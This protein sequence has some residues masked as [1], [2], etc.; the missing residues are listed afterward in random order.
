MEKIIVDLKDRSYPIYIGENIISGLAEK[1]SEKYSGR[2]V[3]VVS[4]PLIF[5]YYG[6]ELVKILKTKLD[7]ITEII[8]AG[9]EYKTFEM[10][11]KIITSMIE[12][13]FNRDALLIALGGGVVGDLAGFAASIYQRGI[14][15]IQVPT[16]LLAQVDSSVGGKVAVNHPLGKNLIGSFYQPKEVWIDLNTL[17]TLPERE[18]K[19]G[20][21]EVI[22]YG[23]LG[24]GS[25][26]FKLEENKGKL[27]KDNL[28]LAKEIIR[29]SCEIKALVVSKDEK[30]ENLRA[31]LNLGHTLGHA[32]ESATNY[33]RYRHGEAIA[34][35]MVLAAKLAVKLKMLDEDAKI[36]IEN[37][38][39][40][41]GLEINLPADVDMDLI[42]NN[43]YLDKKIKNKE[44]VFVLPRKIG[45]VEVVTGLDIKDVTEVCKE[46]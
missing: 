38:I 2:Q 28:T 42:I 25:F 35:G 10:A 40:G 7:C 6:E 3:I 5:S 44:L 21:A 20:L 31:I 36:R 11:E 13:K 17:K 45:S 34:I 14:D 39:K 4:N 29:R 19:A 33:N 26:F 22:K 46:N 37:L 8:P 43:L 27:L 23:I 24:D 18:W 9:E 12:A 41:V 1:I 30:E 32:L 16:T 15:F